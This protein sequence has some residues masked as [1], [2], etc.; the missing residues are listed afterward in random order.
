MSARLSLY[1]SHPPSSPKTS[2]P[3]T[4]KRL[5]GILKALAQ[6]AAQWW[7][8]MASMSESRAAAAEQ[9]CGRGRVS[10]SQRLV[11]AR[12]GREGSVFGL[13]VAMRRRNSLDKAGV[14]GH[15]RVPGRIADPCSRHGKCAARC[16]LQ[17]NK[18]FGAHRAD[19]DQ[20]NTHGAWFGGLKPGLGYK[21]G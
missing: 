4:R 8:S 2:I 12:V 15:D 6:L 19:T 14:K 20:S 13:V 21:K 16:M 9:L 10:G 5:S 11:G 18:L 17:G 7:G 3:A 1:Q